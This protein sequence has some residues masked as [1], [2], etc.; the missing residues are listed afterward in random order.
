MKI[1]S[2]RSSE[3][4]VL[5]R[6]FGIIRL[7]HALTDCHDLLQES[8]GQAMYVYWVFN[9]SFLTPQKSTNGGRAFS[10]SVSFSQYV[11]VCGLTVCQIEKLI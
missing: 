11:P 9:F 4:S 8:L 5:G 2:N 1:I 6:A 10:L 3:A 7:S